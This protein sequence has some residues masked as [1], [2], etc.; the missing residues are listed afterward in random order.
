MRAY[1]ET[2]D[3]GMPMSNES[4]TNTDPQDTDLQDQEKRVIRN[5][6]ESRYEI[7]VGGRL[8]GFSEIR[9]DRDGRV[10]FPHTEVDPAFKG[11]G[12][13]STLVGE[14]LAD[15]ARR[16]E[17]IV[18]LCPFVT[19]YLREHDVAGAIVDWPDS[20]DAEDAASGGESPA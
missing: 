5:E 1:V 4:T 9:T 2:D 11:Q 14:A 6:E 8:G 15:V 12:L 20:D 16:G 13:G 10:V 19:K 3:E 17:T 18:P 7:W